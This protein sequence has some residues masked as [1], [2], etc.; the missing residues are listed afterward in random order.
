M[1]NNFFNLI[2]IKIYFKKH[3]IAIIVTFKFFEVII[4]IKNYNAVKMLYFKD[5]PT[6]NLNRIFFNYENMIMQSIFKL[7]F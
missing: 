7:N 5:I 4:T 6:L 3:R 1:T 2:S